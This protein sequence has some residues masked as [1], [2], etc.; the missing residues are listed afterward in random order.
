ME[1]SKKITKK[2]FSL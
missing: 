2:Q 1:K